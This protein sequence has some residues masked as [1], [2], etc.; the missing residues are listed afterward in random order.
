MITL[1]MD[2]VEYEGY[3]DPLQLDVAFAVRMA[4]TTPLMF[5]PITLKCKEDH[6][7]EETQFPSKSIWQYIINSMWR[8]PRT[9]ECTIVE[10]RVF[11]DNPVLPLTA[12]RRKVPS[13]GF[14]VRNAFP[15]DQPAQI[16]NPLTA[17]AACV[18]TRNVAQRLTDPSRF[19]AVDIQGAPF[20]DESQW[21]LQYAFGVDAALKHFMH[22][23]SKPYIPPHARA[24]ISPPQPNSNNMNNVPL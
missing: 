2:I 11:R 6:F 8:Y 10:G 3:E 18:L 4:V 22:K 21:F 24:R 20:C 12:T 7:P 15:F 23:P 17:L 13:I 1:P 5:E 19:S 16:T 14:I 9:R